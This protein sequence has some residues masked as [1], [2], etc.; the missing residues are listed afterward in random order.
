MKKL[1]IKLKIKLDKSKPNGTPRK[2]IECKIA[3]KYGWE[4]KIG[5][6]KG[7]DLT[8]QNFLQKENIR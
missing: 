1:K 8:Y 7:F 5:L 2:K 4:S 3:K 6:D